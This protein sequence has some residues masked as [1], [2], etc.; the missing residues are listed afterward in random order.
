MSLRCCVQVLKVSVTIGAGLFISS[1]V[2]S[3]R[4]LIPVKQHHH[5]SLGGLFGDANQ[6]GGGGGGGK[7]RSGA[8]AWLAHWTGA[9]WL[10]AAMMRGAGR[11]GGRRGP[12]ARRTYSVL[13][14]SYR[15]K[16]AAP[17]FF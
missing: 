3:P 14:A 7:R 9:E 12:P 17:L 6:Q 8:A 13:K 11:K 4:E 2:L 15:R 16:R 10:A 1:L 5:A